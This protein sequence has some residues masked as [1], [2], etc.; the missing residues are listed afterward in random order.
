[1]RRTEFPLGRVARIAVLV[2][3]RGS[4][5]QALID[6]FGPEDRQGR[7]VL[8]VS[9][10]SGAPALVL[11]R[12]AG[13][14]S[15]PVP[16]RTRREFE[17]E[18]IRLCRERRIDL[19]CL[20]GFMRLLSA[21]FVAEFDGRIVNIHPSL[22]PRFPGLHAQRQALAAGVDESGCTVHIVDAGIDS[23]PI[24]LQRRVP[25]DPEDDE[26]TL[27]KRILEQEHRAYPE[28]LRLLLSGQFS[29][30]SPGSG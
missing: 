27:A 8:V 17:A 12:Q 25:L 14:E 6:E 18:V 1:M 26:G 28:A 10:K 7:V 4:N 22:L 11:A 29:V 3:G 5:L 2:S 19:I 16:W 15:V 9:D 20:A 13:V 21:E 23:G 30:R 24:I